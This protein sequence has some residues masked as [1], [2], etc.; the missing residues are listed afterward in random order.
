MILTSGPH[1]SLNLQPFLCSWA[2]WIN[3]TKNRLFL[4]TRL[5]LGGSFPRENWPS[6]VYPADMIA[7]LAFICTQCYVHLFPTHQPKTLPQD[8][9]LILPWSHSCGGM[10]FNLFL[11]HSRLN[12][13]VT[14]SHT[15]REYGCS[16]EADRK[17]DRMF[18]FMHWR[19]AG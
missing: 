5:H 7:P 3:V 16:C 1:E 15:R 9:C 13:R 4:Y 11:H 19:A 12:L 17:L 14:N 2:D 6:C 8:P 10:C 18:I